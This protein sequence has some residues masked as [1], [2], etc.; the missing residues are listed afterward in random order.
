M[1]EMRLL[2]GI[3]LA[4]LLAFPL[5]AQDPFRAGRTAAP[6]VPKE[7]PASGF[8]ATIAATQKRLNDELAQQ[9]RRRAAAPLS[10]SS[11]S[12]SSMACCTPPDPG[13]ERQWSPRISS[14]A[15]RT[16][17]T[18]CWSARAFP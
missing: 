10:P 13:T 11:P 18:A 7:A 8:V 6:A 3:A 12:P 17:A 15:G 5:A 14:P 1:A 16:G 9:L 4:L 2:L